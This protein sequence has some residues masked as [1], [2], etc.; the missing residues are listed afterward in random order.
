MN[1]IQMNFALFVTMN[2]MKTARLFSTTYVND[3]F[4]MNVSNSLINKRILVHFVDKLY[5]KKDFI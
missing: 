1:R 4:T 2:L 5:D 3:N